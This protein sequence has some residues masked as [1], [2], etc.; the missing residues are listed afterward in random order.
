MRWNFGDLRLF[1]EGPMR[2][3]DNGGYNC[4]DLFW[5]QWYRTGSRHFLEE[6]IH[7]AR[8][9]MD[10]DTIA[11]SQTF[12]GGNDTYLRIAGRHYIITLPL[13]MGLAAR[14]MGICT[15]TILRTCCCAG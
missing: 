6:G 11:H 8:H 7:N 9:M 12:G 15:P 10:V 5:W 1:R 3:W 2:T 14:L 4:S 13:Q